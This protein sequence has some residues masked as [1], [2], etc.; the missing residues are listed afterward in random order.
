MGLYYPF[1]P[2]G[3]FYLYK[4]EHVHLSSELFSIKYFLISLTEIDES[5]IA[6][7]EKPDQ[8]PHD[9]ASDLGLHVLHL[10]TYIYRAFG[11]NGLL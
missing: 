3:L 5:S 6:N 11:L 1:K 4:T 7:R 2:S 8:T 10:C 9:V